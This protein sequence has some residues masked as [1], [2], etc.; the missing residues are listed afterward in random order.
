MLTRFNVV[1]PN[2]RRGEIGQKQINIALHRDLQLRHADWAD[3]HS[4]GACILD[5]EEILGVALVWLGPGG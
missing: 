1:L 3:F 4:G 2:P 5:L